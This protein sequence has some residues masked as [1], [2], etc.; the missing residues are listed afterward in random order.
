MWRKGFFAFEYKGKHKDLT[1]AY[2]QLLL[3]CRH[4]LRR[5]QAAYSGGP[6]SDSPGRSG[7]GPITLLAL[8]MGVSLVLGVFAFIRPAS[9]TAYADVAYEQEGEFAYSADVSAGVYDTTEARTGEPVFRRLTETVGVR[10]DYELASDLPTDGVEGTYKI[11]AEVSADNGWKR[12]IPIEPT[13][14]FSGGKFT[15]QANLE[16]S[17]V[18]RA[19]N[20][21]EKQTG[22]SNDRYALSVVPE[23][24]AKGK[25]AGQNLDDGFSPGIDFWFDSLQLQLQNPIDAGAEPPEIS[26]EVADPLKPSKEGTVKLPRTEP[27]SMSL[28]IF[29]LGSRLPASFR[30]SV[31]RSP[32]GACCGS[33]SRCCVLPEVPS[34]SRRAFSR[35]TR[36]CSSPCGPAT[37]RRTAGCSRSPPSRTW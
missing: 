17:A 29:D 7:G 26:E 20:K 4:R 32:L 12:R 16:L 23:V 1:A 27:N 2:S 33:A 25:L 37:W 6:S 18:Q 9:H 36:P 13:T 5:P 35:N 30:C 28:M 22:F 15:V 10:F 34:P 3:Y 21:L 19:I 24:S 8:V 11:A 14:R 31:S